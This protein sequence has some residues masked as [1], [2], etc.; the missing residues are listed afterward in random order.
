MLIDDDR[1]TLESIGDA[2]S[3][4]GIDNF[5]FDNPKEAVKAYKPVEF[6][7]VILDLKMPEMHGIEVLKTI[8]KKNPDAYVI[9]LTG[10]FNVESTIA[11][12]NAGAFAFL[13]KPA[14]LKELMDALLRVESELK[15]AKKKTTDLDHVYEKY[16]QLKKTFETFKNNFEEIT[17]ANSNS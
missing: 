13:E 1:K 16:T 9:I 12:L 10:V 5:R 15:K 11:V 17:S 7:A 6:D 14:S 3:I 2:L 8:R 4:K